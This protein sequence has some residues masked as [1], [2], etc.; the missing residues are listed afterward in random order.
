MNGIQ[1]D[2]GSDG[3][4]R[5]TVLGGEFGTVTHSMYGP[6]NGSLQLEW[7]GITYT[8][9]E[10]VEL[11]PGSIDSLVLNLPNSSG[12]AIVEDDGIAAN[13]LSR[14]RSLDGSFAT[15]SDPDGNE[16]LLQEVTTR[17]PGRVE[18]TAV[19]TLAELLSETAQH[20]DRFEKASA[21]HDW[22]D[23]YAPY[24]AAREQGSTPEQADA[25]ADA[26]ME[27]AHGVVA[28]R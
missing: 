6:E 1:F 17:L 10:E 23:W 16:F 28:S 5:L 3:T 21:A 20:H 14:I 22:W 15:F 26:Y 9:L 18:K 25:A 11:A 19:A 24:L 8:G 7:N 13:G 4:D 2:G 27:E 12:D